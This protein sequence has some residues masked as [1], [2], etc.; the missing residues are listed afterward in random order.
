MIDLV[1]PLTG[2]LGLFSGISSYLC[3]LSCGSGDLMSLFTGYGG[4]LF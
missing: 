4:R 2:E 3:F 1:F